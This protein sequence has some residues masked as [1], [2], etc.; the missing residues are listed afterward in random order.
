MS[1]RL[2][3]VTLSTALLMALLVLP[4]RAEPVRVGGIS[5]H[6]A[7]AQLGEVTGLNPNGDNYLSVRDGAGTSFAEIDRLSA[8]QEVHICQYKDDF[9]GVVYGDHACGVGTPIPVAQPY[10]GPCKSGWVSVRF[11]EITAG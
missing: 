1:T 4:G 2:W 7:C 3:K 6:D 9:Y 5:D 8:G 10:K 11:I